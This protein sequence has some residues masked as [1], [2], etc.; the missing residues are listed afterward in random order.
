MNRRLH[1]ILFSFTVLMLLHVSSFSQKSNGHPHPNII[2]IYADDLGYADVSCYG[3]KSINTPHIDQLAAQGLL[4]TNA[5]ATAS[6]CTPSRFS[7]LTGKYAWRKEGTG[8]ARGNA[9][10]LIDTNRV[11]VPSVLQQAGYFTGAV[12]KWHLGL[13]PLEG[14]DW[15]GV[16]TPGPNEI[17]F[18][19]YFLMPATPDRV[20]CVYVEDHHVVNLDPAD[21]IK[22]NYDQPVGDWP[23]GK[24]HP[25]LLKMKSSH[26]HNNTIIN[27]IGRIGW[28]TGGKKA[29]W[30]DSTIAEVMLGKAI[31]RKSVV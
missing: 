12:G 19:H 20:P 31:D 5:H 16:I 21:P 30:A 8:I 29:L 7:I 10:L 15:N 18:N 3:G 25:E 4:F 13:G 2:I 14:P 9:H 1:F 23:T 6:T 28:M 26:G 11:T 27:G 24:D 17:G 22:V